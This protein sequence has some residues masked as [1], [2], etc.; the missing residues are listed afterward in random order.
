[1]GDAW[2]PEGQQGARGWV[3]TEW[4]LHLTPL[5]FKGTN[6]PQSLATFQVKEMLWPVHA[7]L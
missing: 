7:P 4:G 5:L 1:M 6:C 2:A 3:A